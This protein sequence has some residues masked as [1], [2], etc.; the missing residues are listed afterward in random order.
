MLMGC[1][2]EVTWEQRPRDSRE[3]PKPHVQTGQQALGQELSLL[4]GPQ[5]A[6][7]LEQRE[8][9]AGEEVGLRK[10]REKSQTAGTVGVLTSCPPTPFRP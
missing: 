9:R 2:E 1:P 7:W 6:V 10:R 5:E 4:T 8:Q 3:F